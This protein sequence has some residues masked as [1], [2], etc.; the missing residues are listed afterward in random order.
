MEP[1]GRGV[2]KVAGPGGEPL[3]GAWQT[4]ATVVPTGQQPGGTAKAAVGVAEVGE[5]GHGG[6]RAS[7]RHSSSGDD[8]AHGNGGSSARDRSSGRSAAIQGMLGGCGGR[9]EQD[10]A[11]GT[12]G[13][14]TVAASACA[15]PATAAVSC[16]V[17][18]KT[19]AK[20]T[21]R[22]TAMT[23][24]HQPPTECSWVAAPAPVG[25][26]PAGTGREV[27]GARYMVA[28]Q[29]KSTAVTAARRGEHVMMM[30]NPEV[31]AGR[32]LSHLTDTSRALAGQG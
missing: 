28:T 18:S 12:G 13:T 20:G 17:A 8:R 16:G 31:R 30:Q 19:H 25:T 7:R 29:A 2:E 5:G 1:W 14:E 10:R 3:L 11:G 32:V 24:D 4:R 9:V 22:T 26:K 15:M 6:S 21:T 23:R 27:A